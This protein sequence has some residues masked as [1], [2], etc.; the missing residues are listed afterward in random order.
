MTEKIIALVDYENIGTLESVRL[1]R[2]ERLILFTGP[3]QEFI[4]FPAVT[5]AGD[6]S[7]SVFR[8]ANVSKIC[9]LPRVFELGRLS[10]TAPEE[11]IF[12]I[13]SN[14]KGYDGVIAE[15]CRAGRRCCRISSPCSAEKPKA[16]PMVISNDE[17]LHLTDK[18]QSL[19][20]K[21]AGNRPANTSS[22]MNYIKSLSGNTKGMVLYGRVK[23]E[24]IRRG[25]IAV[26]EK[27]VVWR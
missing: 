24:L 22:L 6:I 25:V 17:V 12:H 13:I 26:Y 20:K 27:T 14:D 18:V 15:L 7:V 11:T 21:S 8:V 19:S 2:Y 4:R 3:Q 9:G 23:E 10:A 1:S 16:A 5:Y